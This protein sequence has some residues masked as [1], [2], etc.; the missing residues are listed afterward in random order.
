MVLKVPYSKKDDKKYSESC[1]RALKP[2]EMLR[3]QRLTLTRN[4]VLENC[5][6]M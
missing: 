5:M 2:S 3:L 1:M 6:C 4:G